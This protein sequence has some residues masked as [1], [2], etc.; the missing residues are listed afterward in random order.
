MWPLLVLLTPESILAIVQLAIA[1]TQIITSSFSVSDLIKD[2]VNKLWENLHLATVRLCHLFLSVEA[3]FEGK[4]LAH[5]KE[6]KTHLQKL[7]KDLFKFGA[8]QSLERKEKRQ[9][10][11]QMPDSTSCWFF[12]HP[13]PM[14]YI[15]TSKI[16]PVFSILAAREWG[17]LYKLSPSA[18]NKLDQKLHEQVLSK[19][20]HKVVRKFALET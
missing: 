7:S 12:W 6:S 13:L 17:H 16:S 20:E 4:F 19:C 9:Q 15:I 5:A 18:L 11:C 8:S 1:N 10:L 2:E 14:S 3:L